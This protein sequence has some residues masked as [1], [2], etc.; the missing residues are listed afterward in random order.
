M[1][2][3]AAYAG[4]TGKT[5]DVTITHQISDRAT[6]T[7]VSLLHSLSYCGMLTKNQEYIGISDQRK[8]IVMTFRDSDQLSDYRNDLDTRKEAI[9]SLSGATVPASVEVM[10]GIFRPWSAVHTD[11][12]TQF[13]NRRS[14]YP[15]YRTTI[16]GQSLGCSI[17]YLEFP[18]LA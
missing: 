6:T 1:L 17:S 12:I 18:V 8:R 2:L 9:I 16:T 11:V 13:K 4:C 15:S 10:R 14:K 7:Q 5:H 3:S